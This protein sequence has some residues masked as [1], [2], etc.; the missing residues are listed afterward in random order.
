MLQMFNSN[1]T[2]WSNNASIIEKIYYVN[3]NYHILKGT[4]DSDSI[5][6][7]I[8]FLESRPSKIRSENTYEWRHVTINDVNS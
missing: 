8:R 6:E 5:K 7:H 3:M 1:L 4:F 2:S